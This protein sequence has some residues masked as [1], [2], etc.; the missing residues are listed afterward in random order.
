[1]EIKKEIL[2]VKTKKKFLIYLAFEVWFQTFN[3]T[4][5]ETITHESSDSLEEHIDIILSVSP[6]SRLHKYFS[7][8]E[9]L[10]IKKKIK[11]K[12]ERQETSFIWLSMNLICELSHIY[13]YPCKCIICLDKLQSNQ[14]DLYDSFELI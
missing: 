4:P 6:S 8:S 11:K 13:I 14:V 3:W 1:M 12:I 2:R 5:A 7:P 10:T 9:D